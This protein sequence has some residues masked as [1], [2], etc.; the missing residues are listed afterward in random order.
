VVRIIVFGLFLVL[1]GAFPAAAASFDCS[2]ASSAYE[3]AICEFPTL[4]SEDEVLAKAY[5][6]AIGGLSKPAAEEMR[7]NQRAWLEYAERACTDTAEPLE[8]DYTE[9]QV[10]CLHSN[11]YNRVRLL[12]QSRM[13]NGLRFYLAEEFRVFADTTGDSWV[14]VATKQYSSPR[15]DGDDELAEAFNAFAAEAMDS[16]LVP[17]T[18][19]GE[20]GIDDEISDILFE[21]KV[22]TVNTGRI[23]LEASDWWYGHGAAHGNYVITYRHFLIDEKRALEAA[24]VFG[25]TDWAQPLANLTLAALAA[26]LGEDMWEDLEDD[27]PDWVADPSRW[28]FSEDGLIIRF[29]PYEVT[30]YAAGAPT[31]TIPWMDIDA[32]LAPGA[33]DLLSY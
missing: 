2:K 11:L 31:V 20:V 33:R 1:L 32:Y 10:N 16:R 27:I 7:V 24:D 13:E 19:E 30:A 17:A 12:E 3:R 26:K 22:T 29:Q 23:T 4:S 8:G 15:I 28:D 25:M 6:T 18:G 9:D 21:E 14:K 5:A